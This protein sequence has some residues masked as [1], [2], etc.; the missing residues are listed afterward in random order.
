MRCHLHLR[1]KLWLA[2]D[3][4]VHHDNV[5]APIIVRTRGNVTGLDHDRRDAGVVKHDA[6]EGEGS[7]A[8]RRRN[9]TGEDEFAVSVEVLDARASMRHARSN[10]IWLINICEHRA[11]TSNCCRDEAIG[12]RYGEGRDGD[13]APH[14]RE[15]PRST[16]GPEDL[17][18]GGIAEEHG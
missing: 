10:A 9:E 6:E 12:T 18:V 2:V 17:T 14:R 4:I 3:E 8:R 5:M 1:N 7:I 13:V 11:E 15:Q 16:E